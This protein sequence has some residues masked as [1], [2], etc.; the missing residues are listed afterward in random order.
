ML[1]QKTLFSWSTKATFLN[2]LNV[3]LSILRQFIVTMS[4]KLQKWHRN[5]SKNTMYCIPSLLNSNESFVWEGWHLSCSPL[6]I[7]F[8]SEL[9]VLDHCVSELNSRTESWT[10]QKIWLVRDVNQI[11]QF[12]EKNQFKRTICS[13][14]GLISEL[15]DSAHRMEVYQRIMT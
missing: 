6:K 15:A 1:L 11:N 7:F 3:A 2:K 14:I 12:I 9:L 8:F 4:V 5:T 13:L 10:N